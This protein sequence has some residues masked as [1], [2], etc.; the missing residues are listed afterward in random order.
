MKSAWSA[1]PVSHPKAIFSG[2]AVLVVG[3]G[4]LIGGVKIDTDPE[5][6]LAADEP[7]RVFHND[8][9]RKFDLHD[10]VVVGVERPEH[11]QGVFNPES[12]AR[13]Y[14]LSKR[15]EGIEGV[16]STDILGPAHVDDIREAGPGAVSFNWL[17]EGPPGDQ[18]EADAVRDSAKRLPML[19]GTIVSEDGKSLAL[20][21]PV[22]EKSLSHRVS[23]EIEGIIQELDGPENYHFAGLPVAEDTFGFEMFKQ[24]AISAPLA[25]VVIMLLMW[26]FFR[27][28]ALIVS[29][30][31][32]AMATVIITMGA[33]IGMG[34]TVHIMSSMIPIFL[35]P[36]AV[37]DSVHILSEFADLYPKTRNARATIQEVVGHLF[38]PML[39]TS[40][41]SA[42][43]FASLL[44]TPIPPVQ[45]FGGFVAFGIG[46]A[47][48]L[49][50]LF[51]PAYVVSLSPRRLESL[52]A[53]AQT[54][55]STGP[56]SWGVR[57]L[58]RFSLGFSRPVV[59]VAAV[60]LSAGAYGISLIH[61]NDNPVRWF[62]SSHPIRIADSL[63]NQALAG[64]YPA[65][66][67]LEPKSEAADPIE[68]ARRAVAKVKE[69]DRRAEFE[70]LIASEPEDLVG[71]LDEKSFEDPKGED[72]WMAALEALDQTRVN[73]KVFQDP[74]WL[75]WIQG[76]Q[77]HA[78]ES[79]LVG[80]TTA[81][82][83]VV[84]TVHRELKGGDPE[85][86]RIPE[87]PQGVAQTLLTYQSSHRPQD[88]FHVVTPDFRSAVVWFQLRSGDNQD[89]V[90]VRDRVQEYIEAHPAPEP[91][92]VDWAGLTYI[93]VVWQEKMVKGMLESLLG[94]FAV[95]F[96]MMVILFR[97]LLFGL[98]SM[99]PLVFTIVIIYGL[100]G[101]IGKDYD[102]P[103]AVLSSLSL[104]LSVDFAIHFLERSRQL[105]REHGSWRAALPQ[106]FE[107]PGRAIARNAV[108]IALGFIPLLFAPLVPYNTVGV[109][110][111]A[112]MAI[113]GMITLVLLPA[114]LRIAF[115]RG[116]SNLSAPV[117]ST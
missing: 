110:M 65:Y 116:T 106:M 57:S 89:M 42:A 26:L 59:A 51:I 61:I 41:T 8:V 73:S 19:D 45:V 20:F 117:P 60:L 74:R 21:I 36:I 30:M 88:L 62:Q 5:N 69:V 78:Q 115:A 109:L 52:V 72:A 97:S 64:T 77:A 28:F 100:T 87:S 91:V 24:M 10:M 49:T 82:P 58:G 32:V 94:A 114:V 101:V 111:A 13:I 55:P 18:A 44:I 75:A 56:L 15:V 22:R 37:V 34:F 9:K 112:I 63:L 38:M 1:L 50:I 68:V 90:A 80:K 35:M 23:Q 95:V 17:L 113:S 2:L 12:L 43:G 53:K 79:H 83:D 31:V 92:D 25:A 84:K 3:I 46:L 33:L 102:M 103:V 27:S 76:I 98:L 40:L 86:F 14:Q 54:E 96:L 81:L 47:F 70:A 11:P 107:E 108:V 85:A 48:V 104:G 93:N 71:A 99:I 16:V 39:Y 67:V 66:L 105:A 7:A 29:P 4:G 6:M